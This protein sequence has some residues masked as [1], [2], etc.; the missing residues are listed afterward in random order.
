MPAGTKSP[1]PR[2]RRRLSLVAE[3][4]E[5]RSLL[6]GGSPGLAVGSGKVAEDV[7]I[8]MIGPYVSQSTSSLN[9]TFSRGGTFTDALV[10]Q[11]LI[12][13]VSVAETAS[14]AAAGATFVPFN[15]SVTFPAGVDN[16]SLT[17]PIKLGA[18]NPAS[19]PIKISVTT[20]TPSVY[21]TDSPE[22]VTLFSGPNA[23]P[24]TIT[25]SSLIS[26]GT[27]VT[28]VSLTFSEPMSAATVENVH[29]YYLSEMTKSGTINR[30][31][32]GA[33]VGFL[34]EVLGDPKLEG[35]PQYRTVAIKMAQYNPATNTVTLTL[36]KPQNS[37]GQYFLS[38]AIGPG[39]HKLTDQDGRAIYPN[40]EFELPLGGNFAGAS[41]SS[42]S[43][44]ES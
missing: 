43:E 42:A 18:N 41:A 26:D 13:N 37:S 33:Y 1:R 12:L 10:K 36:K 4:L 11:P 3:P 6:S 7:S 39:G 28:G 27:R 35:D 20:P 30:S 23:L 19:F 2:S 24:P 32:L 17:I 5:C 14:A 21:V 9:V 15:G 44:V 29:D 31:A 22:T 25:G 40:G 8:P 34:G 38:N 16:A